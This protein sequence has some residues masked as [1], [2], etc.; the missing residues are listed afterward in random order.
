MS[1]KIQSVSDIKVGM[2]IFNWKILKIFSDE[3]TG[4]KFGKCECQCE[5]KTLRDIRL[6]KFIENRSRSCGC[7]KGK[8]ISEKKQ[9]DL[10]G[11]TFG[12]LK[13]LEN[14]GNKPNDKHIFWKCFCDPKLGGCGNSI[15]TSSA[16]LRNGSTKSCG[17]LRVI[18]SKKNKGRMK[19]VYE[20]KKS[21]NW[22][23][24][25][26]ISKTYFESLRNSAGSRVH[27]FSITMKYIWELLVKQNFKCALS[28]LDIC[29]QRA[30]ADRN[31]TASLDRIDSSKGY[32]EGNVQWVHKDIN[33]IK[34]NLSEEKLFEYCKQIVQHKK[35]L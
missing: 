1:N 35:L 9:I 25:E 5:K 26:S 20:N 13:V 17:C 27:N 14:V 31:A 28:G 34:N 4:S 6:A 21:W 29:L 33:R 12:F 16:H 30:S 15:E 7:L 3:K 24:Y 10:R 18:T 23:G 11:Q 32:I 8:L 19:G 22:K 2:R